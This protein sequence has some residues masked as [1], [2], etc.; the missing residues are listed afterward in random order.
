MGVQGRPTLI[1]EKD[2]EEF[3]EKVEGGMTQR[4]A[5]KAVGFSLAGIRLA[6]K[7]REYVI[8]RDLLIDRVALRI[9]E[10][11]ESDKSQ[12]WWA[13]EF[14]VSQPAFHK[15]FKKLRQTIN[16]RFYRK[17]PGPHTNHEKRISEYREIIAYVQQNGGYVPEAIKALGLKTNKHYVR[18]FARQIGVVLNEWQFAWKEYGLWLTLPGP[19][20][21]LLPANY[22]V[23]A[24][25]RGCGEYHNLNLCNAKS[26]KTH[27]CQKCSWVARDFSKVTNNTTGETYSSVMSWVKSIDKLKQYQKL[28]LEIKEKGFV[29]LDG[30]TYS[31]I[32]E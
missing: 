21:R 19:W 9:E 14:G 3:L 31:V 24:V 16:G 15:A 10:I 1:Q 27:G 25:C 26:G 32:K 17:K 2:I 28:R 23:P 30:I 18:V 4:Q 5:A 29:Q 8:P 6:V 11:R 13:R 22:S 12:A 7:R 20:K